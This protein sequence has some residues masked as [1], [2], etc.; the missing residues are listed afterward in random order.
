MHRHSVAKDPNF[1]M[2]HAQITDLKDTKRIAEEVQDADIM[3][4]RNGETVGYFV[5]PAHYEALVEAATEMD[6]RMEERFFKNY[7]K[8]HGSLDRLD[9]A[10][11]AAKRGEVASDEEVSRVFGKR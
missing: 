9:E 10:Y 6:A 8:R 5:N 3:I 11:A 4:I 7:E 1:P 2:K